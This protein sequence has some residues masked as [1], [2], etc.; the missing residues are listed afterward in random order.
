[1][2]V[3]IVAAILALVVLFILTTAIKVVREYQRIVLF[4]LGRMTGLR[5]PGLVLIFPGID[6][7]VWVD[8][9]EQYLEIPKQTA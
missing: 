4:R 9:R 1:M 2:N 6:R 7:A 8:L 5:G 3:L